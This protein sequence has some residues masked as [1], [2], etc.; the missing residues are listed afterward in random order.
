MREAA[1]LRK[2]KQGK[3]RSGKNWFLQMMRD[4]QATDCTDLSHVVSFLTKTTHVISRS[5]GNTM[6]NVFFC[7]GF[8]IKTDT[9]FLFF[10]I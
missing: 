6:R 7:E 8:C 2:D 9:F 4:L 10:Y 5:I 1:V 3:Q